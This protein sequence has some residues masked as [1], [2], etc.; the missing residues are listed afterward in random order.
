MNKEMTNTDARSELENEI[1]MITVF[2]DNAPYSNEPT[3]L[4]TLLKSYDAEHV[5]ETIM[6]AVDSYVGELGDLARLDGLNLAW[7][8]VAG[9]TEGKPNRVMKCLQVIE[10]ERNRIKSDQKG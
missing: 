2:R 4:E 5:I 6:Q 10:D 1:R 7:L 8:A 3:E 9:V